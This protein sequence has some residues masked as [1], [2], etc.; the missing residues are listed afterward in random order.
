M[1]PGVGLARQPVETIKSIDGFMQEV[2]ALD[3]V[4]LRRID[5]HPVIPSAYD[6]VECP[7]EMDP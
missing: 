6:M 1:E 7:F 4:S 5:H 2:E 3:P